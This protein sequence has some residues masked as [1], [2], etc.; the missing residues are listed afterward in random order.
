MANY[1][2]INKSTD[3]FNTKLWSGDASTQALTGVGH[4]TD[5]VWLKSRGDTRKHNIYDAVRGVQKKISSNESDAEVTASGVTA[6]GTD[7]FTVGSDPD[8]NGNGRT[9]VGWSWKAGGGQGSSN[10]AGSIN[11][12]YTS[13]N[14]TAGFS[15]SSY[16]GTGSNAT[17]GHGLGVAPK[18]ILIKVLNESSS[19]GVYHDGIGNGKYLR[20]NSTNEETASS[21]YWNSTS[22]TSSVFSLGSEGN[23]NQSSKNFISYAFCEKVGYSKFGKFTGNGSASNGTFVYTGF[24]PAFVMIKRTNGAGSWLM[25]DNKRA[26]YNQS[27]YWLEAETSDAEGT[28]A[29]WINILS[30]G[31][32]LTLSG[33][34]GNADGSSYVYMAFA[35]APLVG[36]NNV[37]CTAR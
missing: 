36:S 31:F 3:Y 4:Q 34:N 6:F 23:V 26:G 24:K 2:T 21:S 7:G 17:V 13:V 30:N 8:T 25:L 15:I 28:T 11:T 12:T 32:K 18:V 33:S 14:T 37:P 16:T 35:E 29:N 27:N 5:M 9:Y 19:W 20:L 1:T 10:T 22:P